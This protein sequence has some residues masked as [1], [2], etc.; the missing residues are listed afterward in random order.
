MA[1]VG[2][3]RQAQPNGDL[4]ILITSG[5]MTMDLAVPG[6]QEIGDDINVAYKRHAGLVA[7]LGVLHAEAR[8]VLADTE[9]ARDRVYGT[10]YE[11]ERNTC[12]ATKV[13]ASITVKTIQHR[14]AYDVQVL[15][16][17][18]AVRRSKHVA[19]ILEALLRAYSHR[20]DMLV[21]LGAQTRHEEAVQEG[22]HMLGKSIRRRVGNDEDDQ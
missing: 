20:R 16:A 10:C 7:Q 19:D 15:N 1:T 11:R 22:L 4:R 8:S 13:P 14:L 21:S 6:D 9:E 17:A 2:I 18:V 3:T 5:D 12:A